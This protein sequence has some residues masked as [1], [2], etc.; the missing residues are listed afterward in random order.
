[1]GSQGPTTKDILLDA[2]ERAA[3]ADVLETVKP[4]DAPKID[5]DGKDIKITEIPLC[6]T[7]RPIPPALQAAMDQDRSMLSIVVG[8]HDH[9]PRWVPGS[10]VK[11][12]AWVKGFRSQADADYAAQQMNVAAQAWNDANIGVTFEWVPEAKDA[13][14]VL[15]HGGAMGSVLAE[16]FFPNSQDLNYVF[17][18]SYAFTKDWKKSMSNVFAHE[19]GHVLGLRHEFAIGDVRDRMTASREGKDAVRIDAPNEKS[20]MNYRAEP[21]EIQQSDI[22]STRKFYSMTEDAAGELPQIGGTKIIDYTPL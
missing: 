4:T 21:P 20:V 7:Q 16:A 11:W 12:A 2:V 19:L 10:V 8:L 5:Q 22:D 13:T 3:G 6:I 14:F 15:T 9:I 17:V 18:Y 1:M